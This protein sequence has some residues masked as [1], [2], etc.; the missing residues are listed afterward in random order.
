[1]RKLYISMV[2]ILLSVVPIAGFAPGTI[3][4]WDCTSAVGG[5]G[6]YTFTGVPLPFNQTVDGKICV[7]EFAGNYYYR[8]G[9]VSQRIK[10]VEA[11]VRWADNTLTNRWAFGFTYGGEAAGIATMSLK[12]ESG[13]FYMA[14]NGDAGAGTLGT[15][16][17]S[18]QWYDVAITSDGSNQII[19]ID[20]SLKYSVPSVANGA[21]GEDFYI[22]N[23]AD[24][25]PQVIM[26]GWLSGIRLMDNVQT[27]FPVQ[28]IVPTL[29]STLTSTLTPTY[30]P[31]YTPT[32][33]STMTPTF[34]MT[35][36][37]TPVPLIQVPTPEHSLTLRVQAVTNDHIVLAIHNE[38]WTSTYT[39]L[40][41]GVPTVLY[42]PY[43]VKK[44]WWYYMLSGTTYPMLQISAKYNSITVYSPTVIV[45]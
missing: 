22:G 25:A 36:T 12:M 45:R 23:Y 1:M 40:V 44:Q 19:Y 18:N 39:L 14:T 4:F 31:T 16:V 13:K 38:R 42:F 17:N 15:S 7:G 27:S 6:N 9:I 32:L 28:D 37:N 21:Q 11:Y 2:F 10:T 20:N 34:T 29:T 3:E 43:D 8:T 5:V 41:N 33:T 24:S 26:F 35:M 30:T